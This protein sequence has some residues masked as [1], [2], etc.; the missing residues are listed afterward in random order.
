MGEDN[1]DLLPVMV[2]FT[3]GGFV[4]GAGGMYGG[5]YFMEEDVVLVT[6]TYRLGAFGKYFKF[7]K[8]IINSAKIELI[9]FQDF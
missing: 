8:G 7:Q 5:K 6:V 1:T 9:N 3:G 4:D 2:W